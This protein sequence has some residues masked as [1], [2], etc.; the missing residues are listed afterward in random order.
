V[1]LGVL[2]G[3]RPVSIYARYLL[4]IYARNMKYHY[5]DVE[6]QIYVSI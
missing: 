6:I 4:I 1:A 3:N 2:H 5:G